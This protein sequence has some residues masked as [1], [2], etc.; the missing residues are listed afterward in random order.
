MSLLYLEM[1]QLIPKGIQYHK[2]VATSKEDLKKL[3]KKE[4]KAI[5]TMIGCIKRKRKEVI[6]NNERQAQFHKKMEKEK[7]EK[8]RKLREKAEKAERIKKEMEQLT[9]EELDRKLEE[10]RQRIRDGEEYESP[11]FEQ[12][13]N[14]NYVPKPAE[15][16]KLN[17]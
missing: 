10:R 16:F 8:E 7:E 17:V 12:Y 14:L 11:Y 2:E 13:N 4:T 1:N 9:Q 3:V 6:E 15:Y 5:E